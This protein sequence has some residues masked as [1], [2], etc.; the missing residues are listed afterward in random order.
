LRTSSHSQV[1]TVLLFG[2]FC[3]LQTVSSAQAKQSAVPTQ[4]GV[5][6]DWNDDVARVEIKQT[7]KLADFNEVR[8]V[9]DSSA[10]PLPDKDDNAHE[11]VLTVL[12][13]ATATFVAGIREELKSPSIQA[14]A[15]GNAPTEATNAGAGTTATTPGALQVRVRIVRMNPGSGAAR[16]FAGFGAGKTSVEVEGDIIDGTSNTVLLSF[17]TQRS[18]GRGGSYEK[19]LR[20]DVSDLGSDIGALLAVF[21]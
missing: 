11:P 10:T 15:A 8:V 7:F 9:V 21:K 1:I 16:F 18:S 3:G 20:G 14:D 4:P 2:L 6:Q 5:Y 12:K 13:D 19:L 17:A